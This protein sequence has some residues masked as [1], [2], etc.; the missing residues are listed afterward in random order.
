MKLIVVDGLD[1][2]GKDTVADMIVEGLSAAGHTVSVRSHPTSRPV[3]VMASNALL[4]RS[5]LAHVFASLFFGL[6]ILF[7]VREIRR[8]ESDY[9]V[10]VRYIMGSAYLPQGLHTLVH[11]VLGKSMPKAHQMLFIDAEPEIAMK[12]IKERKNGR[13]MFENLRSL[14]AV[15]RRA[16]SLVSSDWMVVRNNGSLSE[17]KRNLTPY[18]KALLSKHSVLHVSLEV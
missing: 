8:E 11:N 9:V 10:F 12:R 2:A 5:L 15:R 7:S 3:G 13:E 14:A 1:G 18:L 6:D 16:F 17:L 4:K